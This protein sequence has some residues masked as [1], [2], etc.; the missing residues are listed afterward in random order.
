M[1]DL[2]YVAGIIDGE[3][4]ISFTLNKTNGELIIRVRVGMTHYAVPQTL[5]A[6]FGGAIRVIDR[7]KNNRKDIMTWEISR[8]G[9]VN[10][11]AQVYPLLVVKK[12]QA[13][14]AMLYFKHGNDLS[15]ADVAKLK[16]TMNSYNKRGIKGD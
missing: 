15:N 5:Q 16:Q 1:F 9:A 13:R 7:T 6:Q 2:A 10:V 11:L 3:G 4:C 12:E 14:L 8:T